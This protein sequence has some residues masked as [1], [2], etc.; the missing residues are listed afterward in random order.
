MRGDPWG[1]VLKSRNRYSFRTTTARGDVRAYS[2]RWKRGRSLTAKG[3]PRPHLGETVPDPELLRIRNSGTADQDVPAAAASSLAIV[4]AVR[5]T[6]AS[7]AE[8]FSS[9]TLS[10]SMGMR[11]R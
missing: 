8:R 7:T 9:S 1:S 6:M 2:G 10:T 5:L 4:F 3:A 11:A